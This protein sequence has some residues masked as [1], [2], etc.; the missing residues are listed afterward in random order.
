MNINTSMKGVNYNLTPQTWKSGWRASSCW[1]N[2][3]RTVLVDKDLLML[4]RRAGIV[5]CWCSIIKILNSKTFPHGGRICVWIL[6]LL[7]LQTTTIYIIPHDRI[8]D[9]TDSVGEQ[10]YHAPSTMV[11]C[12]MYDR[13]VDSRI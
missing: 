1:R 3:N 9:P 6:M 10:D 2:R 4:E 13:Y 8:L 11:L 7:H 12:Y 5:Y